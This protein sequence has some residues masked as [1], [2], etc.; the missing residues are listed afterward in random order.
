MPPFNC[1]RFGSGNRGQSTA[2]P[3]FN[4]EQNDNN[5]THEQNDNDAAQELPQQEQNNNNVAPRSPPNQQHR[6]LYVTRGELAFGISR[7]DLL[8]FSYRQ[9]CD[10]TNNFS[11]G[12]FIG[13]GSLGCVFKGRLQRNG[14]FV[15]VKHLNLSGVESMTVEISMLSRLRHPNIINLIGY[16]IEAYNHLIVYEFMPLR[17]LEHYLHDINPERGPLDWNTRMEIAASVAKGMDYLHNIPVV[18]SD[19][20][21]SNVLLGEGFHPKL[22]DFQMA[23][24]GAE[25]DLSNSSYIFGN[26]GYWAPEYTGTGRLTLKTDVYS[27]GILLLEIVTG[28]RALQGGGYFLVDWLR[29]RLRGGNVVSIADPN[30]DGQFSKFMLRKAVQVALMCIRSDPDS[31]PTMKEVL[32]AMNNLKSMKYDRNE[33]TSEA[34][35]RL[36]EGPGDTSSSGA[37]PLETGMSPQLVELLSRDGWRGVAEAMMWAT[38]KLQ[39]SRSI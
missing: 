11:Y 1:L 32:I 34:G 39:R 21:S 17:S 6:N 31:R 23:K 3:S 12:S 25:N 37:N 24:F 8:I 5:A 22:S 9:L 26:P 15:A 36:P 13:R 4:Q 2:V 14:Q 35:G 27:F 16:C 28:E 30:L 10:A 7:H 19:L 33:G 29:P 38:V 20:K 18:F